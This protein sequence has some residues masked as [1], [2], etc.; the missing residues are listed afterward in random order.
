M[1]N[2]PTTSRQ[3]RLPGLMWFQMYY[4]AAVILGLVG[5]LVFGPPQLNAQ[6]VLWLMAA[7]LGPWFVIT[8]PW[9]I[10]EIVRGER[11]VKGQLEAAEHQR[12]AL[13]RTLRGM[14]HL[15]EVHDYDGVVA[16]IVNDNPGRRFNVRIKGNQL[17]V[18]YSDDEAQAAV[19]G[20]ALQA[21][22]TDTP[23]ELT[24]EEMALT[25]PGSC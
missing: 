17:T 22:T 21:R 10:I 9:T 20:A 12:A 5:L 3:R 11:A 23:I 8:L 24:F 2:A 15:T 25:S 6:T 4:W 7:A 19:I 14:G 1:S 18:A 16:F 13:L